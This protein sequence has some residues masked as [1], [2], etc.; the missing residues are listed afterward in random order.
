MWNVVKSGL[1]AIIVA[2]C[3][4]TGGMPESMNIVKTDS[5]LISGTG[6]VVHAYRGIPYAA[7]PVANLRWKPPTQAAKWH[8]VLDGSQFG[9]DC[10]QPREYPEL[11]G[12][13]MSEDCLRVNVWTPAKRPIEKL[14]VMVW[15][16]GGGFTYGSGSHPSYDGEALARRGVVVVTLNYRLGLLGFMAH[17]ALT[18]ESPT[19]T[20]GNY[21]LLD[22]IAALRWVQQNIA[23]FG[24]DPKKVTVFGQSAGAH[25]ISELIASPLTDG[26]FSQA[27]MQSVGVMRPTA[28]LAEAEKQGL[29]VGED[30]QSLRRIPPEDLLTLQKSLS[31]NSSRALTQPPEI[32][33]IQDGYVIPKPDY[34][35]YKTGSY[36][37]VHMLV[38]SNQN[39]GGGAV[40]S[41][42]ITNQASFEQYLA[43]TFPGFEDRA[44]SVYGVRIDSEVRQAVA[45][46]FSDTQ[47]NY[48]TREMLNLVSGQGGTVYRYVFTK[49]RGN[50]E[51]MPIH[52]DELQYVFDNL[53]ALHRGKSHPFNISDSITARDMADAW[54]R[55]AKTGNPSG[56]EIGH[57][58]EYQAESERYVQFDSKPFVKA[59]LSSPRLDLIRSFYKSLRQSN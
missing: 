31:K 12:T 29:R 22:Q 30:I 19:R 15:I 33:I 37:H 34:I 32:G 53:A 24:G 59:G 51:N 57:W 17:P 11:R 8:G 42:S 16:H 38:G 58:P 40:R 5:G 36:K 55:F 25:S 27:I 14:A 41:Y 1:A 54:V 7:A 52:G 26:L 13:G 48:G 43:R 39:E 21:G 45:D 20:S 46:L 50:S 4:T 49:K 9:P 18:A 23:N 56:G 2:G 6:D 44:K 28:S 10:I 3:A 35:Q 47:F